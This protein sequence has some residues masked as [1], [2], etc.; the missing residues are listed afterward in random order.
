MLEP[1]LPMRRQRLENELMLVLLKAGC[2][3]GEV[4]SGGVE[5]VGS[6]VPGTAAWRRIRSGGLG[7]LTASLR[8]IRLVSGGVAAMPAAMPAATSFCSG[9]RGSC[10]GLAAERS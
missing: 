6:F 10:G 4:L 9:V 2:A 5:P 7:A 1:S 8:R 3:S